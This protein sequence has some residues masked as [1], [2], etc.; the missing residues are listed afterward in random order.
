[1]NN[2]AFI[3]SQH[4]NLAIRE[5]GWKLDFEKFNIYLQEKYHVRKAFLFIRYVNGNE[6]LYTNLQ[7]VGYILAFRHALESKWMFKKNSVTELI[8]QA[9][10]EYPHY[11][12]AVIVSGDGDFFPLV[13]QLHNR[14]KLEVL[15]I[16]NQKKYSA[17]FDQ[18]GNEKIRFMNNLQ[19]K[20][21]YNN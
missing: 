14:Q 1:M 9:M 17:L 13:Q 2:Y 6:L 20:L 3:D 7:K 12:N 5:Q 11:D 10:I 19:A 4:L 8:L 15:L 16:P 18:I 21:G